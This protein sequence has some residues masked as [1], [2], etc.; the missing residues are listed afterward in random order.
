MTYITTKKQNSN[1]VYKMKRKILNE[2]IKNHGAA[3]FDLKNR[4]IILYDGGLFSI[5]KKIVL[6]HKVKGFAKP[7]GGTSRVIFS[8]KKYPTEEL[9]AVFWF[10][11]LDEIISYL[12]SM[13][14]MLNKLGYRTD[15][16]KIK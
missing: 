11:E 1:K 12:Q 2:W 14:R 13:K 5:E 7:I 4:D 16:K 15:Y 3:S 8:E 10:E 6:R 9:E